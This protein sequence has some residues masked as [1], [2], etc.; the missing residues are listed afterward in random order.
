MHRA[1]R[2]EVEHVGGEVLQLGDALQARVA[3]ADEDEGQQ[4]GAR[5]VVLDGLGGLE[6][7]G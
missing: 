2:V 1:A 3:G 7:R 5:L 6:R 4:R